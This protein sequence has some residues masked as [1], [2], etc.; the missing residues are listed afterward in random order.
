[1]QD[2]KELQDPKEFDGAGN[3]AVSVESETELD[4]ETEDVT[5]VK[6]LV[7][8]DG[9]PD[10]IVTDHQLHEAIGRIQSGTGPIAF[11][12]ERAS[13]FKYRQRAYL[14]QVRREGSGTF[15]IDPTAFDNLDELQ[16]AIVDCDWIVHAASQ[17]LVCLAEVGL[18]PT[19]MLF[20]TELAARLLGLP[21]VGL[22]TL[23]ESYLGIS[24]AKEHSASDWSKRPFP[25]SWLH[26]AAL[27]VDYLLDLWCLIENDLREANKWD[28]ALQEFTHVKNTTAVIVRQDPWRRV[29]GLHKVTS[30]SDLAVV[31]ALWHARDELAAKQD[32]APGRLLADSAIVSI[33]LSKEHEAPKIS[34]L[35][36]L[37][38]RNARRHSDLWVRTTVSA[39]KISKDQLP[40]AKIRGQGIPAPKNWPMRNPLAWARLEFVRSELTQISQKLQI[41]VENLMTP[42]AV[43]KV[44]WEAPTQ[45]AHVIEIL[46]GTAARPWQCDIVAPVL[47]R[48]FAITS[49]PETTA[50][51]DESE[52]IAQ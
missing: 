17:D 40:E 11:D 42:D 7:A 37:R 46:N 38:H 20:D 51:R 10:V 4:S 6:V 14:I 31:R 5:F 32:I 29:S 3:A 8:R 34:E 49:V 2:P 44:V 33:A 18:R 23:V 12:A 47:S 28:I 25:D 43:R 50:V 30:V 48:A 26:Y 39:R 41:P 22:G 16:E 15:L 36:E 9:L 21:R 13:G 24:L 19:R 27:D 1:M 45:D 52:S 35:P